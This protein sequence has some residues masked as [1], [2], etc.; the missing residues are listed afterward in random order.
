M[1]KIAILILAHKNPLQCKR[2]IS[3]LESD[4]FDIYLHIDKKTDIK[5]L[6]K[7]KSESSKL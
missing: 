3:S 5:Q 2:L 6:E 4:F 1:K 7:E